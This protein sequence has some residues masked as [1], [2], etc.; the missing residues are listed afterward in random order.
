M[1]Y[2]FYN[3]IADVRR[4]LNEYSEAYVQGTDTTGKYKNEHL[5][6]KINQAYRYLYALLLPRIPG[7]FSA[8]A[9][10]AGVSS[11]FTLPGDMGQLLEVRDQNGYKVIPVKAKNIPI[12]DATGSAN[13]YYRSGGN[14]ITVLKASV[15][16]T[17]DFYY[18]KKARDLEFG[19]A[20]A[21]GAASI[22]LASTASKKVDFYNGME[23][24]NITKDWTDTIDAYAT[25][26]VATIS[27]TAA[28]DDWYGLVPERPEAFHHLLS[29]KA[30]QLVKASYPIAQ[31]R[32]TRSEM[33]L[34]DDMLAEAIRSYGTED[35]D[36]TLADVWGGR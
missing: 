21:G 26:R 13:E 35:T 5:L 10:I 2:D 36:V 12:N 1:L 20:A 7:Y 19:Q 30:V 22:T 34:W 8:K 24:Q 23:I 11:V 28:E 9:S 27:E 31:E 15:S 17:Y 6:T 3:L 18:M 32:P 33:Q 16:A 4:D 25:T 29:P 14:T